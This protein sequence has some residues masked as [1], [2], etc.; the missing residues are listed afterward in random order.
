MDLFESVYLVLS[1]FTTFFFLS[2]FFIVLECMRKGLTYH[3]LAATVWGLGIVV[4]ARIW[5]TAYVVLD[6]RAVWG[7]WPEMAEYAI[8]FVA[9]MVFFSLFWKAYR[10]RMPKGD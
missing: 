9:Y 6:L 4:V 7:K 8:Y 1:V 5:H 3:A 10:T 2:A